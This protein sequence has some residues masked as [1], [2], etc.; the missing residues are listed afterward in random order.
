MKKRERKFL[1]FAMKL[2]V[3]QLFLTII[4]SAACFANHSMGQN[5]LD[6]EVNVSVQNQSMK[7]ILNKISQTADVKFTYL[8]DIIPTGANISFTEKKQKLKDV[9]KRL[10]TPY[11]LEYE[12]IG[13]QIILKKPDRQPVALTRLKRITITGKVIA[14]DGTPLGNASVKVKGTTT[15]TTTDEAGKFKI[16]SPTESGVLE[17]S[18][19]GYKMAEVPFNAGSANLEITLTPND[20]QKQEE[21][22]VIGYGTQKRKF[23]TDA[24]ATVKA[25][26]LDKTTAAN[27]TQALQ[28]KAP[29]IEVT[30]ATGQPGA[31][32]SLK[33]RTNPSN[34]NAGVLYVIDG[35]PVNDNAGAPATATRYGTGGVDQS[36]LNFINP[37]DIESI[38]FLKD[39]G[40][41][42]IYGA[43]AGAG[44]VLITTKKGSERKPVVNYSSAYGIQ[45][46]DRLYD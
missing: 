12:V 19:I 5:V 42:S 24:V 20:N 14:A 26:E 46:V 6:R 15:G 10:L 1:F 23:V 43:R 30:Q 39:A 36:P 44:V 17:V 13:T 3:Q 8:S 38:S 2:I 4:F 16:E 28:G 37:N 41:A 31:N 21:V 33:I 40:S 9:L 32:V 34:A 35:V 18:Y 11:A 27:F 45:K 29:G 22:V 25:D 7:H